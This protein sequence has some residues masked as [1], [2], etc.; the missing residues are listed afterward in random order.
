VPIVI[1]TAGIVGILEAH[2]RFNVIATIRI[3]LGVFTFAL[4]LATLQFT[5]SIAMATLAL[6]ISRSVAFLVYYYAAGAVCRELY[7]P[8]LPMR[9]HVKPLLGYGGWLTVSNIVGPLMTYLDRVFISAQLGLAAVTYYVTPYEV[10]SRLSIFSH[11]IMAVMFPAMA[12]T[13]SGRKQRLRQLYS[14]SSKAMYW[15]MLPLT[16]SAFLLAPEALLIWLGEDFRDAAT[17]VVRWLAAGWLVNTMAL[18]AFVVLQASG[19]PDL[20]AKIH[21]LELLPYLSSL[22]IFADLFGIAGVA[23]AWALRVVVDML[24]LNTIAAVQLPVLKQPVLRSLT[25]LVLTVFIFLSFL[26]IDSLSL[27]LIVMIAVII[28]ALK[29]LWPFLNA[30]MQNDSSKKKTRPDCME[31]SSSKY[32]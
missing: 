27:R 4:P 21:L 2:Q 14:N 26:L 31:N 6:L 13:H 23:A 30:V 10:L 32:E 12:A 3:P 22:F 15:I 18:P 8:R 7:K 9:R 1:L 11:A 16:A 25:A 24:A 28:I 17:P 19:R 20:V 29:T 5:P